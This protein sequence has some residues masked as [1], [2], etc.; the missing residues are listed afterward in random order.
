MAALFFGG[1]GVVEGD[2]AGE[3]FLFRSRVLQNAS[4]LRFAFWRTWLRQILPAVGFE[5]CFI[6]LVVD[7]LEEGD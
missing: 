1:A 7:L 5:D 6:Q 2:E 3:E 4:L